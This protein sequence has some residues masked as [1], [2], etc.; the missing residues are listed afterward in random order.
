MSSE[1]IDTTSDLSKVDSAISGL[2]SSPTAEKKMGHRRTSSSASGVF[3]VADLGKPLNPTEPTCSLQ[4]VTSPLGW[5]AH[6]ANRRNRKRRKRTRDSKGDSKTQLVHS[7]APFLR[8]CGVDMYLKNEWHSQSWTAVL[9]S[10]QETQYVTVFDRRSGSTQEVPYHPSGQEDWS[11]FPAWA[12]SH[13]Q[14]SE[15]SNDQ[16][17]FGRYPQAIQEEGMVDVVRTT[18]DPW[19]TNGRRLGRRRAWATCTGRFRVG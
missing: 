14:E 11:A 9:K 19:L 7:I 17:R 18:L 16:G 15:G 3:N 13:C 5:R 4:R 2:S 10:I 1:A 12:W 8:W 6:E